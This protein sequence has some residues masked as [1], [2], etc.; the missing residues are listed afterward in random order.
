MGFGHRRER[1]NLTETEQGFEGMPRVRPSG[2]ARVP[3]RVESFSEGR[4]EAGGVRRSSSPGTRAR[5]TGKWAAKAA[6][7]TARSCPTRPQQRPGRTEFPVNSSERLRRA[8]GTVPTARAAHAEAARPLASTLRANAHASASTALTTKPRE[9]SSPKDR[10][11][12]RRRPTGPRPTKH[13][14]SPATLKRRALACSHPNSLA[15]AVS[16]IL[17][18]DPRGFQNTQETVSHRCRKR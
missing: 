10:P 11:T 18:P 5:H 3:F 6:R 15:A 7:F 4:R 12:E 9:N 13:A 14:E 16:R 8:R 17:A 1:A 2:R